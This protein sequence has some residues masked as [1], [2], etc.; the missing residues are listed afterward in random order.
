MYLLGQESSG[1]TVPGGVP[2]YSNTDNVWTSGAPQDQVSKT[3]VSLQRQGQHSETPH[4]NDVHHGGRGRGHRPCQ[5]L[6]ERQAARP[7]GEELDGG[8]GQPQHPRHNPSVRCDEARQLEVEQTD[9]SKTLVIITLIIITLSKVQCYRK[10]W[11]K[12]HKG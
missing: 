9:D 1:G 5:P 7:L 11:L 12:L 4:T 10:L 6:G 2:L 3:E 8:G